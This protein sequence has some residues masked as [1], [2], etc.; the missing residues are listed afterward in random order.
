M[1]TNIKIILL[2]NKRLEIFYFSNT[3]NNSRNSVRYYVSKNT[4]EKGIYIKKI[5]AFNYERKIHKLV[6]RNN[7]PTAEIY[8]SIYFNCF[9]TKEVKG[10][11]LYSMKSL[12]FDTRLDYERQMGNC[13][14]H[15]HK[16]ETKCKKEGACIWNYKGAIKNNNINKI[17]DWL[18]E[19][20]IYNKEIVFIHGDYQLGNIL[21]HNNGIAAILDW[22]FAG[23]G[24]RESDI[25]W[26]ITIRE[27]CSMYL[28]EQEVESFIDGYLIIG[29]INSEALLWCRV[30][31]LLFFY[32][33][34]LEECNYNYAHIL[35]TKINLLTEYS[36]ELEM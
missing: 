5:T 1:F 16:I 36:L 13:L 29:E 19:N 34:A 21:L 14:A 20:V 8:H 23:R 35:I 24:W 6:S 30:G 7:I 3:M 27:G 26:A 9:I 15:I 11:T 12:N 32:V 33:K 22:E 31:C 25:A 2:I 10:R 28:D 17:N 4:S 18:N